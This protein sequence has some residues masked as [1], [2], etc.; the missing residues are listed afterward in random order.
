LG[1]IFVFVDV[2][3]KAVIDGSYITAELISLAFDIPLESVKEDW[4]V[5]TNIDLEIEEEDRAL[6]KFLE[7]NS[8]IENFDKKL[9]SEKPL[10]VMHCEESYIYRDMY[11]SFSFDYSDERS[12][13]FEFHGEI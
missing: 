3:D 5:N 12:V 9:F 2:T 6:K 13:N 1:E 7:E 4:G 8:A 10:N 11:Y